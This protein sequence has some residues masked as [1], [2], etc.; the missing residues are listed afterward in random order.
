M[1]PRKPLERVTQTNSGTKSVVV[2]YA[3]G[4]VYVLAPWS[5]STLR[6][7]AARGASHPLRRRL[8]AGLIRSTRRPA[9]VAPTQPAGHACL[10]LTQTLDLLPSQVHPAIQW[11][12]N[13]PGLAASDLRDACR[14]GAL[15]P[16]GRR[17]IAHNQRT[18]QF[19][20]LLFL[21]VAIVTLMGCWYIVHST[22][23]L[24]WQVWML[25][26]AAFLSAHWTLH[27]FYWPQKIARRALAMLERY[28]G[29]EPTSKARGPIQWPP[30]TVS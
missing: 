20:T 28:P 9:E 1:N 21:A 23:A 30:K 14:H 3:E 27:T 5:L 13:Q 19:L 26:V 24:S 17:L 2:G 10:A 25:S 8:S 29:S 12:M 22:G 4:S 16:D 18:D 6:G 11:L 15:A 7:T